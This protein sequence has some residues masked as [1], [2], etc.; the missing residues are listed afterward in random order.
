MEKKSSGILVGLSIFL[1][2]TV[3][4]ASLVL[5]VLY[6]SIEVVEASTYSVRTQKITNWPL[7]VGLSIGVLY[8]LFFTALAFQVDRTHD[9]ITDIYNKLK[10]GQAD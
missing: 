6:G 9:R 5:G 3:V 7:I 4:I 8:S 10:A 2:I 1:T